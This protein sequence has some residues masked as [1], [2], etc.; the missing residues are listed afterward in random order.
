MAGAARL[1]RRAFLRALGGAFALTMLGVRRVRAAL[2][3]AKEPPPE[4]SLE[5][6]LSPILKGR[7]P[8]AERVTL[9]LPP[10]AEDG[11]VVPVRFAVDSPMTAADHVKRV[12]LLVDHNPD[13]RILTIEC[14]P[15]MGTEWNLKIR[16][17]ESSNVRVIAEMNDDTLYGAEVAILVNRGGCE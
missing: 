13:P 14:T 12:H 3:L 10:L 5:S 16:M 11:R 6:R 1:G 4:H 2:E 17:R 9:E 7:T 15:A 8:K